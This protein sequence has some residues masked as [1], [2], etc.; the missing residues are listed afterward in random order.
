MKTCT[1]CLETKSLDSF[2]NETA[3]KDGKKPKC[4]Q[5][6][7][8]ASKNHYVANHEACLERGRSYKKENRESML[9]QK[10][11]AYSAN[12]V[13]ESARAK[14]YRQRNLAK[15]LEQV[16]VYREANRETR[17]VKGIQYHKDNPHVGRAATQRRGAS[18]KKAIPIWAD[19]Y[20]IRAVYKKAAA[21]ER[22]TG[23]K[24]HV[25]HIVP[26][27]SKVVCGLHVFENLRIVEPLENLRK[28]N[29]FSELLAIEPL[30]EPHLAS[31][32][33]SQR[34]GIQVEDS[35]S[36]LS[37]PRTYVPSPKLPSQ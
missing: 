7:C 17:N 30:K 25:D 23:R 3:S 37:S 33:D 27:Q 2:H 21:L 8:L 35:Y 29:K 16:R 1:R 22:S 18:I 24:F 19:M 9:A 36:A 13:A 26:L 5:C 15:L 12:K 11:A 14:D 4:K 28:S 32:L 10:R 6:T 34:A 31:Y 20:L